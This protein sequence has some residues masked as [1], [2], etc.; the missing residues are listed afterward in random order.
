MRTTP[1]KMTALTGMLLAVAQAARVRGDQPAPVHPQPAEAGVLTMEST[2]ANADSTLRRVLVGLL[3]YATNYIVAHTPSYTVRH[4]WYRHVLGIDL[5][6]DTV[7][8]MGSF[9]YFF[10]PGS[11]RRSAVRVGRNTRINRDCSI[12]LRGGVTIGADVR[13]SAE[14]T[15]LTSAGMANSARGSEYRR[16]VIEDNAWIGVRAILMPG[17]TV[18]RGAVV[19]AGAVVMADVPPMAIVFGSPARAVGARTAEDAEYQLGGSP[20]LFE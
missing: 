12:D 20:P 11:I 18:G 1:S 7:V 17:V 8:H 15:I 14:V 10:S 3:K 13:I 16:V 2:P 9:I 6:K 4:F 5:A 19:G